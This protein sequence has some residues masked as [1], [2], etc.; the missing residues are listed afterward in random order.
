M[1]NNLTIEKLAY[2]SG[3]AN[4]L[5]SVGLNEEQIKLA[6]VEQGF[7][8]EE[9]DGIYKEAVWKWLG[10]GLVGLGKSLK[11]VG[12]GARALGAKGTPALQSAGILRGIKPAD[13]A[14]K[15]IRTMG[16][17]T[18]LWGATRAGWLPR[19]S[20]AFTEAGYGLQTAPGATIWSGL[21]QVPQGFM[22]SPH[23]RGIGGTLGKGLGA[24]TFG[25]W[26]LGPGQSPTPQ[27]TQPVINVSY[28]QFGPRMS[29][30]R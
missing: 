1:K 4:T 8:P 5:R 17:T 9:A 7:S 19:M 16:P 29:G 24:Y 2:Y 20:R 6:F 3:Q 30:V 26:L 13:I 23:A 11:G 15:N 28:P 27:P 21:K 22:V 18:P 10:Q 25:S 12:A 14:L